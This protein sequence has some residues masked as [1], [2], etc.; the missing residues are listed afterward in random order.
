[1]KQSLNE[2]A[3]GKFDLP[4]LREREA[5]CAASADLREGLAAF[6]AQREPV[7]SGR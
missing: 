3:R 6:S 5:L 4:R 1:M 7:F 2:I